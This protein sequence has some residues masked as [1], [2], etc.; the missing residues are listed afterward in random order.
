MTFFN[1]LV[2]CRTRL[3]DINFRT[4]KYIKT[5]SGTN[6]SLAVNRT[7]QQYINR[8]FSVPDIYTDNEFDI[9]KVREEVAPS[10]I[11]PCAR[12]QHIHGTERQGQ[13][14][15]ERARCMCHAIPFRRLT[16]LMNVSIMEEIYKWLN[17]FPSKGSKLS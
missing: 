14:V 12:G 4:V 17:A 15:K 6:L 5:R 11:H 3:R 10:K 8:G 9:K 1:G 7:L 16:I 2:F 13:T